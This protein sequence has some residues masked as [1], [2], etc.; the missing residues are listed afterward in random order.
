MKSAENRL[1][2]RLINFNKLFCIAL[3][4]NFPLLQSKDA[5]DGE[6]TSWKGFPCKWKSL[7][8]KRRSFPRTRKSFPYRFFPNHDKIRS[9]S[10]DFGDGCL[11]RY[12]HL[13][14]HRQEVLATHFT[15]CLCSFRP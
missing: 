2:F 7:P 9:Y 14:G 13:K 6:Q 8:Y 1:F 5:G 4:T 12:Q 11:K 3:Q 10:L 15:T